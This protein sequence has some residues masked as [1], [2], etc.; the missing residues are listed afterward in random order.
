MSEL[1]NTELFDQLIK[2]QKSLT[3]ARRMVYKLEKEISDISDRVDF[4]TYV[5]IYGGKTYVIKSDHRNIDAT[6]AR[7]EK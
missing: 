5:H 2:K 7:S 6:E 1:R 4:G 3:Q